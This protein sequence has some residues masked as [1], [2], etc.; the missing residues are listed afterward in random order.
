M[1]LQ[2]DATERIIGLNFNIRAE[3]M[4]CFKNGYRSLLLVGVFA[5]DGG[6][7]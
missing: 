6:G 7:V 1:V 4:R 2:T 5:N 3:T